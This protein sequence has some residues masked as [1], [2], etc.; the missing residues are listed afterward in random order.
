MT[1]PTVAW[2]LKLSLFPLVTTS[3]L[4]IFKIARGTERSVPFRCS[5]LIPLGRKVAKM[6]GSRQAVPLATSGCPSRH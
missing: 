4:P 2:L 6:K 5:M 1:V 3:S